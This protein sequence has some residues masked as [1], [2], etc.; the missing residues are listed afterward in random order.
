MSSLNQKWAFIVNPVAGNHSSKKVVPQLIKELKKREIEYEI[1]YTE[2]P[3]HATELSMNLY[4]QGYRNI[5]AVGGD[6]TYNELIKPLIEKND[7]TVGIVPCGTGNDFAQIIG[8]PDRFEEEDWDIFFSMNKIKIDVG[9]CNGKTFANGMGLGFDAQVA[10]QNYSAPGEVKKGGKVKYYWHIVKTILFY[11]E[12]RMHIVSDDKE[13]HDCFINT[14]SI[15]RRYAGGFMLTPKAIAND[16]LFDVCFI[17]KISVPNRLKILNMVPKGEHILDKRVNYYQTPKLEIE[18]N[19]LVPYHL[20]GELFW[21]KYFE[22]SVIP[23]ALTVV[24]NSKGNH[25]F[26]IQ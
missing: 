12:K 14:I 16:G 20:D 19:D 4:E 26:D 11:K 13:Y 24:Y 8:F 7:V 18:F 17:G 15:G 2:V 5:F 6:G 10:A 1:V 25:Y 22:V 23:S 3:G 21:D 9:I